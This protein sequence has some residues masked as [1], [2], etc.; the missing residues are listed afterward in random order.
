MVCIFADGLFSGLASVYAFDMSVRL[1][2]FTYVR[3][4]LQRR[5][6]IVLLVLDRQTS[7]HL[8]PEEVRH[9]HYFSF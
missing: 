6:K 8:N 7:S 4:A 2:D 1:K 5:E 3:H 9:N